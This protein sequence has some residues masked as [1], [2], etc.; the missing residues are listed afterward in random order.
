MTNDPP[1]APDPHQAFLTA[2]WSLIIDEDAKTAGAPSWIESWLR[3]TEPGTPPE[4]PAA[5]ALHRVLSSGVDPDDLTDVVRR[6]QHELAYNIC[7]LLDDPGLLDLDPPTEW[8]LVAKETNTP[9]AGLHASLDDFDPTARHGAARPR[10][11]PANLPSQPPYAKLAVAQALAGNR[12]QAITTW[13]QATGAPITEA[14]AA[15][16]ALL[17][18]PDD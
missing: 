6:M 7:Q 4:D 12:I 8:H 5:A 3:G 10:P 17:A 16:D 9:L 15:L 2:L 18:E 13:R 14:K 11:I 1:N